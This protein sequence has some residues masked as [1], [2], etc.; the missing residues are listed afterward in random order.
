MAP[1]VDLFSKYLR[2]CRCTRPHPYGLMRW[3]PFDWRSAYP[4]AI[5]PFASYTH[6]YSS[7]CLRLV[8][9]EQPATQR[10][11]NRDIASYASVCRETSCGG[12]WGYWAA[13]S[14]SVS[15]NNAVTE[16]FVT[17][18]RA[19]LSMTFSYTGVKIKIR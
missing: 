1:F 2:Y 17:P 11:Y 5:S 16:V 12:K 9:E 15:H 13:A 6:L 18:R 10:V 19:G 7:Y 3:Q 4:D 14:I 8:V